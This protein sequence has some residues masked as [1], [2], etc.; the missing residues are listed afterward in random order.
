MSFFTLVPNY[1]QN[2]VRVGNPMQYQ[3]QMVIQN[4]LL[5]K[6]AD[7]CSYFNS[8]TCEHS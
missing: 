4:R 8:F 3:P 5:G 7:N 6:N 1:M 2:V